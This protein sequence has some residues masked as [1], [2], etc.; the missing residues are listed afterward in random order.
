MQ[1]QCNWCYMRKTT[2]R[3]PVFKYTTYIGF[4]LHTNHQI[5]VH[6]RWC[7]NMQSFSKLLAL[8]YD[9]LIIYVAYMTISNSFISGAFHLHYQWNVELVAV[10]CQWVYIWQH[11][12]AKL[13]AGLFKTFFIFI[14]YTFYKYI[15]L[16]I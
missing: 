14:F 8:I 7:K 3:S 13:N 5:A 15:T 1:F 10:W 16:F 12:K 4:L 6:N 11:I 2:R 9:N